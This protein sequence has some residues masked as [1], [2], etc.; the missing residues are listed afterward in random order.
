MVYCSVALIDLT[1]IGKQSHS[2]TRSIRLPN[3]K[4]IR[5]G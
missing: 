2:L 1:L 5:H 4:D 3:A